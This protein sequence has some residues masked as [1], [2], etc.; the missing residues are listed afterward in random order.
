MLTMNPLRRRWCWNAARTRT[1][2][3][4]HAG[5]RAR[6]PRRQLPVSGT[7]S[8]RM[9]QVSQTTDQSASGAAPNRVRSRGKLLLPVISARHRLVRASGRIA[10]A[11]AELSAGAPATRSGRLALGF[12]EQMEIA[13]ARSAQ[14]V[15]VRA[16][17]AHEASGAYRSSEMPAIY[18]TPAA[19]RLAARGPPRATARS[20]R[21]DTRHAPSQS[22]A[23]RRNAVPRL[24]QL[25]ER[26][27]LEIAR[28]N[29]M[30]LGRRPGL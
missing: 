6:W 7:R 27:L 19:S 10:A 11:T 21:R 28:E 26:A 25:R 12:A 9:V 17:G 13:L 8:K 24:S 16:E 15:A 29:F 20:S 18:R 23:S 2:A 30:A 4:C 1:A 3:G 14:G 22:P 5:D